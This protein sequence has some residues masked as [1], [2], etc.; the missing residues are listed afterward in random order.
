[1]PSGSLTPIQAKS[2]LKFK[3]TKFRQTPEYISPNEITVSHPEAVKVKKFVEQGRKGEGCFPE[4]VAFAGMLIAA[5]VV[6]A[7]MLS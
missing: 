7:G 4:V 2:L 5:L 6:A 1:M 3:R